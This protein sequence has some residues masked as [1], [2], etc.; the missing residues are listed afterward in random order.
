MI[1]KARMTASDRGHHGIEDLFEHGL[2]E[3][4]D[5]QAR[6]RDAELHRRD[7]ARRVARDPQDELRPSVPLV[8]ELL[9]PRP[10]SRDEAVLR[11]DEERVQQDQRRDGDEKECEVHALSRRAPVRGRSSATSPRSIGTAPVGPG[12]ACR[13]E[14]MF[15]IVRTWRESSTARSRARS[16]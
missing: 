9:Q 2:A 5:T 6:G 7:E 13:D 16:R 10:A 3:G 1:R 11:G 8:G 15:G 14:H 12:P 4:T